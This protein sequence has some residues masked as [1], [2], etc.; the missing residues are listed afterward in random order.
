MADDLAT[1]P[2]PTIVAERITLRPLRPSD[3]GLLQMYGGD[4]RVAEWTRSIPHP[5]PPGVVEAF[6]TRSTAATRKEDIWAIDGSDNGLGEI[7]GVIGLER[8]R[9]GPPDQSEIGYWVAPALWNTGLAS[10]ALT[11]L[12]DAN[13]QGTKTIFAEVFQGND[14]SARVLT[15]AGFDYIGDAEAFCVARGGTAQTWNYLKRL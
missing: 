11:A 3:A 12:I 8:M 6:I 7:V 4:R 15:N 13:P 2:Q 14:R 1:A 9:D 10:E 5:M